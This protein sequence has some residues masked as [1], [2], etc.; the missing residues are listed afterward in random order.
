MDEEGEGGGGVEFDKFRIIL[1]GGEIE[2]S[3]IPNVTPLEIPGTP[4]ATNGPI[5]HL[6]VGDVRGEDEGEGI[7]IVLE[8]EVGEEF[9]PA[10]LYGIVSLTEATPSRL[11]SP[12]G[13]GED[14][15]ALLK[16]ILGD[17]ENPEIVEGERGESLEIIP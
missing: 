10:P 12:E 15:S 6:Q 8:I 14:E 3:G 16:G 2:E 11:E 7:R 13:E 9:R 1:R 5:R 4:E 17:E